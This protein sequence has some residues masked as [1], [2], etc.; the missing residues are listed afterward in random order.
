ML[1]EWRLAARSVAQRRASALAI[2]LTL[3]LGIGANSAIFSAIDTVLLKP[4]PYP[5]SDR[6]VSVFEVKTAD[7]SLRSLVAPVRLE[8]WNRMSRSFDGLAAGYFENMTDA[9]GPLPERVEARRTSPRY[10]TVLGT[11]AALGRTTTPDEERFGGP[12]SVVLSDA[13]WRR[14]FNADPSIVGRSLMLSGTSRT[15]VGVMPPA[16]RDPT[17]TTDVWIPSQTTPFMFG[18]RQARF[19]TAFGRLKAGLTPESAREELNAIQ[20]GLG[21]Q[22]PDTDAG[23]A[24][25]VSPLKELQVGGVRRSLWLLFGAALFVL[26]AACGNIACLL[27]AEAAR[28]EHEVAVR[29]AL[30]ATRGTIVRQL[31]RE[32]LL[33]SIV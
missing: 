3:T 18:L 29:F 8:E 2:L 27:L 30:G 26:L 15:I 13:F 1:H 32:S 16:F 23:W 19:Y 25:L 12:G 31:L 4:L 28:R 33:L 9:S 6:L 17:A 14:R 21:R 11:P 5:A 20:T 7:A 10:F 24:A 22:F